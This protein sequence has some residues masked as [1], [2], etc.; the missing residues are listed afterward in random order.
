L[1]KSDKDSSLV[2][3]LKPASLQQGVACFFAGRPLLGRP[4]QE[5]TEEDHKK[6]AEGSMETAR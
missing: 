3:H 5:A 2:A 1:T 4:Q 6:A